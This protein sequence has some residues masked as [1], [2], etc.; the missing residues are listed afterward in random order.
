[1]QMNTR[2]YPR[3]KQAKRKTNKGSSNNKYNLNSNTITLLYQTQ[4]QS[5]TD[6]DELIQQHWLEQFGAMSQTILDKMT[7]IF[8]AMTTEQ[9]QMWKEGDEVSQFKTPYNRQTTSYYKT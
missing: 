2:T 3:M 4:L 7:V 6:L 9:M 1:M 5:A 8:K